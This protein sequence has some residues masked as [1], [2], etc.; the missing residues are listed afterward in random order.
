MGKTVSNAFIC[1]RSAP[2]YAPQGRGSQV[3]S[4]CYIPD[5]LLLSLILSPFFCYCC[6][7]RQNDVMVTGWGVGAGVVFSGPEQTWKLVLTFEHSWLTLEQMCSSSQNPRYLHT[8]LLWISFHHSFAIEEILEADQPRCVPGQPCP[9]RLPSGPV[10]CLQGLS[11]ES[12]TGNHTADE[13]LRK[14]KPTFLNLGGRATVSYCYF[15]S[16]PLGMNQE[17]TTASCNAVLT[18]FLTMGTTFELS[19][20]ATKN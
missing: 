20:Q 7:K 2:F 11:K 18:C 8:S 5:P 14:H 10:T 17:S 19:K 16:L 3:L 6:R 15:I 12:A 4:Q 1:S 13:F 9:D